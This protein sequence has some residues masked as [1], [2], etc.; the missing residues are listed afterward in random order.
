MVQ[1]TIGTSLTDPKAVQ[2]IQLQFSQFKK[3]KKGKKELIGLMTFY[4]MR[5]AS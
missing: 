2:P 5:L 4:V 1:I 3:E